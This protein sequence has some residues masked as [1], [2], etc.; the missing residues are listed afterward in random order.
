M[1]FC[2]Q[3]TCLVDANGRVKLSARFVADFGAAGERVVLHC[4]PEGA[5]GVY[6]PA[7]WQQMRDGEPRPAGAVESIVFRRELRRMGALTQAGEITNQGRIT[8]PGQ[9]RGLLNL[10]PGT[11]AVIV[12]CE[13]GVEIWNAKNWQNESQLLREHERQKAAVQMAAA[14]G[15]PPAAQAQAPVDR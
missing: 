14:V 13:I 8:V 2:G 11:E 4:L 1:Q 9:F 5:L 15:Q 6:P 7:V 10:E 3:E 12:G